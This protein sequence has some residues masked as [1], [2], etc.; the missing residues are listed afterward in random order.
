MRSIEP[1][2]AMIPMGTSGLLYRGL[3]HDEREAVRGGAAPV[4]A[5]K[6]PM[7]ADVA[8][9]LI[10]DPDVAIA[11]VTAMR[12]FARSFSLSK[13]IALWY[14]TAG[15]TRDGLLAEV[16]VPQLT[17]AD[18]TGDRSAPTVWSGPGVALVDP[19]HLLPGTNIAAWIECRS[20]SHV[21]HEIL[22]VRGAL[23]ASHVSHVAKT[24][25]PRD[26]QPW[27][28]WGL[29][30]WPKNPPAYQPKRRRGIFGP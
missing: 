3:A 28:E 9:H 8:L 24:A 29:S 4:I 2:V 26:V 10:E 23:R 1:V 11:H 20:R 22:L 17:D 18:L 21:D 27:C 14:A 30:T 12:E 16:P 13:E 5:P 19:R 15:G 25:C 7:D 6:R